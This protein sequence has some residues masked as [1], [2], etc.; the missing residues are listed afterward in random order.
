MHRDEAPG[1]II[2]VAVA[3]AGEHAESKLLP[4]IQASPALVL[5][6]VATRDA[7][8]AERIRRRYPGVRIHSSH[9]DDAVFDAADLIVAAGPPEFNQPIVEAALRNNKHVFCEKPLAIDRQA[10]AALLEAAGAA[11]SCVSAVGLNLRYSATV[12]E[13]VDRSADD[14]LASVHIEYATT[15][16]TTAAWGARSVAATCVLWH[17]IHVIDLVQ[18]FI[19]PARLTRVRQLELNSPRTAIEAHLDGA[20]CTG[21]FLLHNCAPAFA[22]TIRAMHRSGSIAT[23][24]DLRSLALSEPPRA[25]TL[26]TLHRELPRPFALSPLADDIDSSGYRS[27]FAHIAHSIVTRSTPATS[28]D[29][30]ASAHE[31]L[32]DLLD[33]LSPHAHAQDEA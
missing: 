13:L 6:S 4:A 19:G 17:A 18:M 28:F 2:R 27:M 25:A 10:L 1:G 21:S 26:K 16:P 33:A 9:L 24:S 22:L 20:Q 14:P 11:P 31:L 7:V 5:A 8:K 15:K 3:G 32:F 30:A 12:R 23:L 29:N